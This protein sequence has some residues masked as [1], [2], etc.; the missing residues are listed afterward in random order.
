[1]TSVLIPWSV[2]LSQR[3]EAISDQYGPNSQGVASSFA[4]LHN[5]KW[6]SRGGSIVDGDRI[7]VVKSWD[8][9]LSIFRHDPRLNINGV[10]RAPCLQI[11]DALAR[12]ANRNLC[13]SRARKDAT[14]YM[15]LG[16]VPQSR[17]CEEQDLVYEYLYEFVS[18]LLAEIIVSDKIEGTYFRE[19]LTWFHA[20]HFPCGWDG[21]WPLGR[22]RVY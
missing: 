4:V 18:M 15:V 2:L 13:W 8:E 21:E 3:F 20:G 17:P 14:E 1:M 12:M 6:L 16:G 10:L 19:Q 11:D 7:A 9:A 5:T 22:M